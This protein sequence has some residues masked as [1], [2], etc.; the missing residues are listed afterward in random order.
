MSLPVTSSFLTA[1]KSKGSSS[2]ATQNTTTAAN[3][4]SQPISIGG[5]N[6]A[7]MRIVGPQEGKTRYARAF[8]A[9]TVVYMPPAA[10]KRRPTAAHVEP[11]TFT[12]PPSPSVAVDFGKNTDNDGLFGETIPAPISRSLRD[13][14]GDF[15]LGNSKPS[16]D[17]RD[18][19]NNLFSQAYDNTPVRAN[20]LS[21]PSGGREAFSD[22]RHNAVRK[23]SSASLSSSPIISL[24]QG[25]DGQV[26]TRPNGR[27][28][29][30]SSINSSSRVPSFTLS[31]QNG[32]GDRRPSYSTL[33]SS[34]RDFAAQLRASP[35]SGDENKNNNNTS[36]NNNNNS[37]DDD[38]MMFAISFEDSEAQQGLSNQMQDLSL[39]RDSNK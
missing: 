19:D 17:G 38:D 8:S 27:M 29:L 16:Y 23:M 18:D 35:L 11:P 5:Y 20:R 25:L 24:L 22:S 7:N 13:N 28:P 36:S 32:D 15:L 30:S 33:T 4:T 21:I 26:K 10:P 1:K 2:R 14:Y 31:P 34:R 3:L 37:V 12:L 9:P 6:V 39:Y